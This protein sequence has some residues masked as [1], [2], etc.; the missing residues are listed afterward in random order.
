[1]LVVTA[2]SITP[3][4]MSNA[5]GQFCKWGIPCIIWPLL[6]SPKM[7]SL[8]VPSGG[9]GLGSMGSKLLS[10]CLNPFP[11]ADFSFLLR[12]KV[13]VARGAE[14]EGQQPASSCGIYLLPSLLPSAW[15]RLQWPDHP[16]SLKMR[17][18]F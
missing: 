9:A 13:F 2:Y 14:F 3:N 7:N 17:D 12:P 11:L 8:P 1:M 10:Q 6:C 4:Q 15:V 16:T 5:G 18:S